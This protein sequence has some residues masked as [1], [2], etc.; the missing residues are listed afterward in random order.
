MMPIQAEDVRPSL[1]YDV[2]KGGFDRKYSFRAVVLPVTDRRPL[3]FLTSGDQFFKEPM[4]KAVQ[5]Q[6]VADLD[7]SNIFKDVVATSHTAALDR[8][9]LKTIQNQN[10]AGAVLIP[11]LTEFNLLQTEAGDGLLTVL[12]VGLTLRLVDARTGYVLWMGRHQQTVRDMTTR[13][14]FTATDIAEMTRINFRHV[15]EEL[16]RRLAREGL[17]ISRNGA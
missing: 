6:L 14:A 2:R 7:A 3:A 13:D 9:D 5:A 17:R 16:K 11:E 8:D 4:A 10:N 15:I 1:S 12:D